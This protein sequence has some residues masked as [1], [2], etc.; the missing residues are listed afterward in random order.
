MLRDSSH[1]GITERKPMSS[2]VSVIPTVVRGVLPLAPAA[3]RKTLAAYLLD[4][5]GRKVMDLLPGDNDIRR[6]SPGV[7]FLRYEQDKRSVKIIVQ[8]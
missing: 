7:Y 8:R 3:G 1:S 5:S 6:L 2:A 4:I